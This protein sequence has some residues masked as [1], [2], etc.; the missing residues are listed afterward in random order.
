MAGFGAAAEAA[1]IPINLLFLGDSNTAANR[2]YYIAPLLS[3]LSSH[4]YSTNSIANEGHSGYII[5]GSQPGAPRFGL[6]ENIGLGHVPNFL[7]HP[8]VNAANTFIL[9]MIG[10]NDVDTGYQLDTAQLQARMTGLLTAIQ[11]EAPLAHTIVATIPPILGMEAAVEKFNADIVPVVTGRN[12]SLVDIYSAFQPDPLPYMADRLHPNQAGGN[13]MASVW[14]KGIQAVP[15]PSSA[16]LAILGGCLGIFIR[17]GRVMAACSRQRSK[18]RSHR[19]GQD[20]NGR[21]AR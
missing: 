4:G 15:E 10:T 19:S 17:V 12:L 5:D 1:P 16:V 2:G 7:D 9:L 20:I 13:L 21:P 3:T 18:A 6:R 11:T 14:F 8:N